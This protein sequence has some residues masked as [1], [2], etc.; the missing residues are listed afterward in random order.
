MSAESP[1]SEAYVSIAGK[2][3]STR[4]SSRARHMASR[5]GGRGRKAAPSAIAWERTLDRLRMRLKGKPSR[6][7]VFGLAG[8]RHTKML[9]MRRQPDLRVSVLVC[10]SRALRVKPATFLEMMLAESP[11][12]PAGRTPC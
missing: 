8:L 12:E 2:R 10:L 3:R 5:G 9:W 11:S 1:A 7:V 6:S 4:S